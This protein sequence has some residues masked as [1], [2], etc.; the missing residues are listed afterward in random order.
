[1]ML[2]EIKVHL[3][4]NLNRAKSAYCK[5]NQKSSASPPLCCSKVRIKLNNIHSGS[6]DVLLEN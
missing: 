5:V 4:D 2:S 6:H 3:T 1:M